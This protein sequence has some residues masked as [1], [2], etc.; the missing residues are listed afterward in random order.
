MPTLSKKPGV[1]GL[2][3]G[4]KDL[5]RVDFRNEMWIQAI[6]AKGYRCAWT[7][8]SQCPCKSVAEQTDQAD[9]NCE[10][11]KGSGWL[12]FRPAGAVSNPKIIGK[13]NPVQQKVVDTQGA[14]IH[15]IMTSLGN[16]KRPWEDVGPRLEGMSMCTV[17]AEN[18]LGFYDRLT[19]L[20]ARIVYSQLLLAT[21]PGTL[22][23][24][25]YPVVSLN[26][27]R[28]KE[29]VYAE[30]G[31]FDLVV[32][33]IQWKPGRGPVLGT[34]LVCHYLCHPAY[35]VI[36]HPHSVRVTSTKFKEKQPTT[37]QGSPIDLP[38]QAMLKYEFLL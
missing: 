5:V 34:P 26:I 30:G 24:T 19:C 21:G 33:D 11:C 31:D 28:T 8:T 17:R 10:L 4:V 18:K 20:D 15:A 14:V 32:G 37:P 3:T 13:L 22:Q 35:R 2:P 27:L 1:V 16:T 9:P 29:T 36:E 25:R 12:F 6:E 7:Q 38:V 23:V